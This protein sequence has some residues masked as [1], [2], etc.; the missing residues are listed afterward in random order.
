MNPSRPKVEVRRLPAD[1]E[2]P[3]S[4]YL[5]LRQDG[6]PGF[7][8]ESVAG[9]EQLARYSFLGV[10]PVRRLVVE[11]GPSADP[12]EVLRRELAP[13]EVE[14]PPGLPPFRGGAVGSRPSLSQEHAL[15]LG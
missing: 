9:G 14:A 4:A 3:V 2:T 11:G 5:K 1:L 15:A 12:L 13:C 7:L 8:L 6:V 10:D